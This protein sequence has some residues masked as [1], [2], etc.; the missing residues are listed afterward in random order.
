[1]SVS[2]ADMSAP[3]VLRDFTSGGGR[4][5]QESLRFQDQSKSQS[6]MFVSTSE[7]E[8]NRRLNPGE[9][10]ERLAEMKNSQAGRIIAALDKKSE[11]SLRRKSFQRMKKE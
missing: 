3:K 11:E 6:K 4:S 7:K 1:M 8:D 2:T 9:H 5:Q 10:K